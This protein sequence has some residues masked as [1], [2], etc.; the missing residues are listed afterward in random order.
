MI[1]THRDKQHGTLR[2]FVGVAL[3][4]AGF[5]AFVY[6]HHHDPTPEADPMAVH[7]L[8]ESAYQWLHFGAIAA[9]VLG[10]LVVARGLIAM[11]KHPS[12]QPDA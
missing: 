4:I 12:Q 9:M 10:V 7:L 6:A 5:V 11:W 3:G 1:R 2:F 8:S